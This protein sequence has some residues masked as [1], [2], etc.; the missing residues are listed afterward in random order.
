[1]PN[2][3][4]TREK[5]IEL[6]DAVET[7]KNSLAKAAEDESFARSLHTERLNDYERALKAWNDA[8]EKISK[9]LTK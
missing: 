1:M 4:I 2:E 7:A 8:T 5:I 6:Y 3:K 9:E